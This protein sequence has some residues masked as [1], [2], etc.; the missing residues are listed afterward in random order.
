IG[1]DDLAA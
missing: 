1:N